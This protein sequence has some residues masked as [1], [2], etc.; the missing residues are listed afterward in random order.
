MSQVDAPPPRRG[1]FVLRLA[2]GA[3]LGAAVFLGLGEL[4]SASGGT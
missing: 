3:L 4:I 1:G 2:I